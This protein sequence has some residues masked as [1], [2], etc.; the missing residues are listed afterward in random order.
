MLL[1]SERVLSGRPRSVPMVTTIHI[2]HVGG[3]KTASAL[4]IMKGRKPSDT[5]RFSSFPQHRGTFG[6]LSLWSDA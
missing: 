4:T 1:R 2:H 5:P 6:G 3:A